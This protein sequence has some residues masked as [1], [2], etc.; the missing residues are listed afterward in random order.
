MP[1]NVQG[2]CA[3]PQQQ[4]GLQ[5]AGGV[6]AGVVAMVQSLRSRAERAQAG[7]LLDMAAVRVDPWLSIRPA[8]LCVGRCN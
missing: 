1:H 8:V 3:A 6:D 2:V 7:S 4:E 5:A